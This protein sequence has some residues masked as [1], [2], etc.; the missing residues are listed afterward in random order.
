MRHRKRLLGVVAGVVL[1]GALPSIAAANTT[2]AIAQTGGMT[3]TL[4]GVPVALGVTLD[5]FGKIDT[6]T[7]DSSFTQDQTS[8]HK[9]TFERGSADGS[10]T[11]K[12]KAKGEKLSAKV[13][14]SNLGDLVGTHIWTGDIFGTG[15]TTTVTFDVAEV[16]AGGA[17]YLE[18]V[19]PPV[20]TT[21]LDHTIEGPTTESDDHD[22][23]DDE[24]EYES[25]A[26]I[27]FRMDGFKKTLKIEVETEYE[28]DDD[29]EGVE[30]KLK[31]ELKGK[32]VQKLEGV[33][34]IGPH[35]WTGLLC[36]NTTATVQYTVDAAGNV[37]VDDVTVAD[38]ASYDVDMDDDGF[39]IRFSDTTGE[40]GAYVK[41][42][43]EDEHGS[44]ELK[45][46]SKTT[47]SCDDD[48]DDHDD[49]DDDDDDDKK[50]HD[51]DDDDKKKD[52]DKKHD[53]D[54]NDDD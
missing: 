47:T 30:A 1:V 15:E 24:Y 22:S 36:D 19:G 27:E 18:I 41:V 4:P 44:L 46:K 42:K 2:E 48:D 39:K 31:I 5:E 51:D 49:D 8:D 11:V 28:D 20:V 32:D 25:K 52:D 54:D 35:T 38:G 29:H 14:T 13:K 23:D 26:K 53:D 12:V 17:T 16:A 6:V 37:T 50:K 9:V 21:T 7:F 3:L 10:T 34:A 45:V 43:V 33:E 40:D